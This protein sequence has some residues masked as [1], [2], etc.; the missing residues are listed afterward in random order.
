MFDPKLG[1][2]AVDHQA[3]VC[4]EICRIPLPLKP[5]ELPGGLRMS[6]VEK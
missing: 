3:F 5:A 6:A 2:G 4:F 1:L